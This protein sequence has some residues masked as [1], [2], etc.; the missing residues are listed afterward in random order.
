MG[1]AKTMK[2]KKL[3]EASPETQDDFLLA[4]Q[5]TEEMLQELY[6]SDVNMG[7]AIGGVLT[8]SM[9]ELLQLAPDYATAM[10]VIASCIHNATQSTQD[11]RTTGQTH[12]GTPEI[13]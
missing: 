2:P 9:I 3:S 8:Q 1:T 5:V 6:E 10:D 4:I 13:H 7:A 11:P 12:E